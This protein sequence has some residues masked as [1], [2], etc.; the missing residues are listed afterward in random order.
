MIAGVDDVSALADLALGRLR[1]KRDAL[2]AA[3]N[4]RMSSHQ[5]FLLA[6]QLRHI[7]DL[8]AAIAQVGDEIEARL[9]PHADAARRLQDDPRHR[10]TNRADNPQ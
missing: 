7:D 3:L 9:R 10:S 1:E 5:R 4:G 6:V 8:D 2:E